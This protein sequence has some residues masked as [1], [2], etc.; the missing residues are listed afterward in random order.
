MYE[1]YFAHVLDDHVADSLDTN[2]NVYT[3]GEYQR[4]DKR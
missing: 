2:W 4:C 3:S 1:I